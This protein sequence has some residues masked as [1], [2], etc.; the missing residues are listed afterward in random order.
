MHML[1]MW[2]ACRNSLHFRATEWNQV[3][4][5]HVR[6]FNVNSISERRHC[7]SSQCALWLAVQRRV[8]FIW[9]EIRGIRLQEVSIKGRSWNFE[10]KV[11]KSKNAKFM[12]MWSKWKKFDNQ[13]K[14][15]C[16]EEIHL[17]LTVYF[18]I[19]AIFHFNCTDFILT[20]H[21]FFP[22]GLDIHE[23]FFFY[24]DFTHKTFRFFKKCWEFP[25]FCLFH[26]YSFAMLGHHKI[27]TET[28][29]WKPKYPDPPS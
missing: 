9:R 3:V 20:F 25:K 2:A 26:I 4:R 1:C 22:S 18:Y 21:K 12:S 29:K 10:N 23:F 28:L 11:E 14:R 5:L 17:F 6:H 19:F 13:V 7:S 27:P 16:A 15:L 24:V 8:E